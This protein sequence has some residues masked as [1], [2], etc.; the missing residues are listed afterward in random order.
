MD[1]NK[2]F[3]QAD[4]QKIEAGGSGEDRYIEKPKDAKLI[5]DDIQ[6]KIKEVNNVSLLLSFCLK[7]KLIDLFLKFS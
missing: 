6:D 2:N 4:L 1:R 5:T 3:Y 7:L